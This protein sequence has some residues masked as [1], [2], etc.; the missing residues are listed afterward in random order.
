MIPDAQE[1]LGET[2]H[3]GKNLLPSLLEGKKVHCRGQG[4]YVAT[5]MLDD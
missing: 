5:S 4:G 1:K 2:V 3:R